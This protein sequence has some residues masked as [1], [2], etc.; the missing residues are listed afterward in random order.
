[1]TKHQQDILKNVEI[2]KQNIGKPVSVCCSAMELFSREMEEHARIE[3]VL[4]DGLAALIVISCGPAVV[5]V[6]ASAMIDQVWHK[7]I[8]EKI[9][10]FTEW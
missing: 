3:N 8:D 4:G 1:M 2:L 7:Q 10:I 9:T 6:P 5:A